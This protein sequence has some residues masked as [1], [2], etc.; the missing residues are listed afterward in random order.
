MFVSVWF[1][2]LLLFRSLFCS[3]GSNLII[4]IIWCKLCLSVYGH[5]NDLIDKISS[6]LDKI[7]GQQLDDY[8]WL[9]ISLYNIKQFCPSPMN[10]TPAVELLNGLIA[11]SWQRVN[12]RLF[13]CTSGIASHSSSHHHDHPDHHDHHHH[14]PHHHDHH[15]PRSQP[16]HDH[17]IHHLGGNY[18]LLA[19]IQNCIIK[20]ALLHHTEYFNCM[21]LSS[22]P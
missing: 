22:C 12:S 18:C 4:Q 14:D 5:A 9:V 8:L 6:C 2:L 19:H 21:V 20:P 11:I 16:N 17:H 13:Q 10:F 3:G 15:D 1:H 7:F